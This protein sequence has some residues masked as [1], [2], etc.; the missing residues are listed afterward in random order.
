MHDKYKFKGTFIERLRRSI[1][2]S[3][4]RCW[5]SRKNSSSQK[6]AQKVTSLRILQET[7]R[8]WKPYSSRRKRLGPSSKRLS[9]NCW[10]TVNSIETHTSVKAVP[11]QS[12]YGNDVKTSYTSWDARKT[13]N[14]HFNVSSSLLTSMNRAPFCH[15]WL[16]QMEN[17]SYCRVLT[18]VAARGLLKH[19]LAT[20][21]PINKMTNTMW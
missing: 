7:A 17:S 5:T 15:L 9:S 20:S 8:K 1:C 14:A 11:P 4:R 13:N 21:N 10:S 3:M 18:F 16:F 2:H 12:D 19:C 6:W